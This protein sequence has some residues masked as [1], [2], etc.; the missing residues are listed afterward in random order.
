MDRLDAFSTPGWRDQPAPAVV[1]R[2]A[3]D[4]HAVIAGEVDS[5]FGRDRPG[6]RCQ[7]CNEI[8]RRMTAP[9]EGHLGRSVVVGR[10]Q[11]VDHLAS[12]AQSKAGYHNDAPFLLRVAVDVTAFLPDART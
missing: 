2:A 5:G 10:L 6:Q 12:G 1:G 3:Q 8:H 9:M 7:P 11:G 4:Q